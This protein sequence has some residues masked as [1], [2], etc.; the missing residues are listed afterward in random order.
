MIQTNKYRDRNK[1]YFYILVLKTLNVKN[2]NKNEVRLLHLGDNLKTVSC[3]GL[4]DVEGKIQ[5]LISTSCGA[6]SQSQCHK[7]RIVGD[8]QEVGGSEGVRASY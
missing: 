7:R 2:V 8:F 4:D 1:I 5:R 3:S 6:A